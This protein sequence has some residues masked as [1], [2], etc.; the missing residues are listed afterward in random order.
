MHETLQKNEKMYQ[1]NGLDCLTLLTFTPA[2]DGFKDRIA[3]FYR[4]KEKQLE[5]LVK[6]RILPMAQSSVEQALRN[7]ASFK[8][9]TIK[10]ECR[11]TY[12]SESVVSI[13]REAALIRGRRRE[14]LIM[15]SEVWDMQTGFLLRLKALANRRHVIRQ[16]KAHA[17][18]DKQLKKYL[19]ANF[20]SENFYL[21][22]SGIVVYY[23]ARGLHILIPETA[24]NGES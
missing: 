9:W 14:T 20:S 16:L 17:G 2:F 22:N 6:R 24:A 23:P 5:R 13:L 4:H 18:S 3:V 7:N 11:L 10:Y 8:P 15:A 19:T 12:S 1:Y 21:T